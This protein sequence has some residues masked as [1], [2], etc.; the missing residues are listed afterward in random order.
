MMF[1]NRARQWA[2]VVACFALSLCAVAAW[3][4]SLTDPCKERDSYVDKRGVKYVCI[5]HDGHAH[6]HWHPHPAGAHHHHPHRHPHY[7][8][9]GHHHPAPKPASDAN[10]PK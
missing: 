2:P 6:P 1:K 7:D 5:T 4:V 9:N 3:A 10:P 8:G